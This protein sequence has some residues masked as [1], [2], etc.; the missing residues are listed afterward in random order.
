MAL[1]QSNN[2]TFSSG[3]L[4]TATKLNNVKAVQ[5]DTATNN[6]N[7]T[8]SA[9][10]LTFDTTANKLRVHDGSTAGGL[11]VGAG[12]GS[13]TSTEIASDAVTTA[14]INDSAVT[15]AKV[16][17]SAITTAK[18]DDDAVTTA[19]IAD[20]A[21]TASQIASNAVDS[22]EIASDAVTTAKINDSAVTTAKVNDSAITTAKI[23]DSAVTSAKLADNSVTNSKINISALDVTNTS[24]LASIEVGALTD[25]H[26][27]LKSP[28]TDDYD[29]RIIHQGTTLES[30]HNSRSRLESSGSLG[31]V[32]GAVP[33]TSTPGQEFVTLESNGDFKVAGDADPILI[34]TDAS[35]NNIGMGKNPSNVFK[36]DVWGGSSH[37]NILNCG[38]DNPGGG[39]ATYIRNSSATGIGAI[40]Q[41]LANSSSTALTSRINL[42][43]QSGTNE[44]FQISFNNR[45]KCAVRLQNS[46]NGSN[47]TGSGAFFPATNGNQDL[48]LTGSRWDDVW[49]NG[50]FNGSDG[51]L[52][53]DVEGL[54]EAEKRV[55][56]KAK[57][58]IKKFRWKDAV[59]KKGDDA[60]IHVG[61]IAQELVEAFE[62]EG[63]DPFRYSMLGKDTWWEGT[64]HNGQRSVQ[65]KPTEGYT[66][67]TQLSVRYNELLAFIISA[68]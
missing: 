49:S 8:G 45:D 2:H 48:G 7:F 21:I 47:A 6:N 11:E 66:E 5:T 32:A 60:R 4:V 44:F 3:E 27:D 22:S 15:T 61:V 20:N 29:L 1:T 38:A 52:K 25:S 57:G 31:L 54:D 12:A 17:D 35:A 13:V 10:Q 59:E 16:N 9:G 14:K 62:S 63:L 46:S 37:P 42:D 55:A 23:A 56:V 28:D 26:I 51:N 19:K 18:I 68:L 33:S 67:V 65:N 50:T 53:Q 36:L 24:G 34:N 64:D 39:V 40:L 58:L 43:L 30:V 41:L